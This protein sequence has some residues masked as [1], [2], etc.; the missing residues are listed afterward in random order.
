MAPEASQTH[1]LD[2]DWILFCNKVAW[3]GGW[4]NGGLYWLLQIAAMERKYFED[5]LCSVLKNILEI[6]FYS[7]MEIVNAMLNI[8][9]L[10]QS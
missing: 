5:M 7:D 9:Y 1:G 8:V 3:F 10:T 4:S 2:L 6:V